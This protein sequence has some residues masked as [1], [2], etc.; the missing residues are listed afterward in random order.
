MPGLR[1]THLK[2]I[3]V[4][5]RLSDRK[6]DKGHERSIECPEGRMGEVWRIQADMAASKPGAHLALLSSC[7]HM[8]CLLAAQVGIEQKGK[9]HICF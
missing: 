2:K 3:T 1:T 8:R 9:A 6:I 4:L 5:E 7:F